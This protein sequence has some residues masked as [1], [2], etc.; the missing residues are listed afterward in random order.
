MVFNFKEQ[1][2]L[3]LTVN[4][5]E[6][7]NLE[8]M[9]LENNNMENDQLYN[10]AKLKKLHTPDVS[11]NNVDLKHIHSVTSLTKLYMRECDL[12]N[13]DLITS[14]EDLDLSSNI[15]IDLSPQHSYKINYGHF[16]YCQA[17][18]TVVVCLVG[19]E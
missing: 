6:L 3:N 8:V 15:D 7:E 1:Q 13:I 10:L 11:K 5:L 2:K 4:D 9:L 16:K 18:P 17:L 14:L 19:F 12:K